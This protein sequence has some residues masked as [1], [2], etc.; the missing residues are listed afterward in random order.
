MRYKGIKTE[1]VISEGSLVRWN[2]KKC[3]SKAADC[4]GFLIQKV[5]NKSSRIRIFSEAFI[6]KASSFESDRV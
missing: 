1:G 5:A 6:E 4:F 3:K 2:W